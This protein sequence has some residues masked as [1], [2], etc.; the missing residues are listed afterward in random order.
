MEIQHHIR[1]SLC[2]SS[3]RVQPVQ[4]L[5]GLE[6][7]PLWRHK[8][9]CQWP[10]SQTFINYGRWNVSNVHQDKRKYQCRIFFSIYTYIKRKNVSCCAA[11]VWSNI[12]IKQYVGTP[13]RYHSH[14]RG[15]CPH[16]DIL[17]RTGLL[18]L[19]SNL[20]LFLMLD[21]HFVV[22]QRCA[23]WEIVATH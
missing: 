13:A 5:L 22:A 10:L 4:G 14:S 16:V 7:S 21:N 2:S 1:N 9:F 19:A 12:K 3:A 15:R 23:L 17:R 18:L 6:I 11:S 20:F 8:G